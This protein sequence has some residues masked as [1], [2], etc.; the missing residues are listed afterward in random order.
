MPPA[1]EL[2][3]LKSEKN[4]N[5]K[6]HSY[7]N[8]IRFN[9]CNAKVCLLD[10]PRIL[11]FTQ[12]EGFLCQYNSL[13]FSVIEYTVSF[14]S[15]EVTD[16]CEKTNVSTHSHCYYYYD[17]RLK[18]CDHL[19]SKHIPR[20]SYDSVITILCYLSIQFLSFL[21]QENKAISTR[22]VLS[23]Y[24]YLF[25]C[26][27]LMPAVSILLSNHNTY[28]NNPAVSVSGRRTC[29]HYTLITSFYW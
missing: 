22:C 6:R 14:D 28:A 5:A 4:G 27:V 21:P 11:N 24:F 10:S 3:C 23:N 12:T 1:N 19:I 9:N 2:N 29:F 20:I 25:L 26:C 16:N 8:S 18:Y 13:T 17:K 7:L 15:P